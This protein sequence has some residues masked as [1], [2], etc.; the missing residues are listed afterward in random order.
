MRLAPQTC[1]GPPP[2]TPGLATGKPPRETKP[3]PPRTRNIYAQ[4]E[5]SMLV[6]SK[7][8][9]SSKPQCESSFPWKIWLQ[10][11]PIHSGNSKKQRSAPRWDGNSCGSVDFAVS[12][13]GKPIRRL[14]RAIGTIALQLTGAS[15]T[16]AIQF[17]RLLCFLDSSPPKVGL[18]GIPISGN[19]SG[20]ASDSAGFIS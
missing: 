11:A 18:I 3:I 14:S 8:Q 12:D 4:T 20:V 19:F 7:P 17:R 16:I 1:P 6:S 9:F 15:G 5:C 2:T 10:K 13:A